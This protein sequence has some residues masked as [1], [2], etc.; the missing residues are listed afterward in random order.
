[1]EA[2]AAIGLV[3]NII[4]FIDFGYEVVS[5]GREIHQAAGG[6][7]G[8]NDKVAS[9]TTQLHSISFDLKS[10]AAVTA[11][12]I[13][14]HG[15]ARECQNIS[16]ELLAVLESLKAKDPKSKRQVI[17]ATMKNFTKK[18]QKKALET[19]L[20]KCRDMLHLQLSKITRFDFFL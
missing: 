8:E 14:L 9:L 19:R 10:Q 2:L 17:R 5:V 20:D 6:A 16:T 13:Q 1:M 7:T 11:D 3:S 15:L 4:A 18:D 12:E